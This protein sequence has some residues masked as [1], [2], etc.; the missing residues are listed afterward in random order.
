MLIRTHMEEL[1]EHTNNH[2]YERHRSNKLVSMGVNQDQSVFKEVKCVLQSGLCKTRLRA[3]L[4][5]GS[6]PHLAALQPRW[7]RNGPPTTP[8]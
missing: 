1:K 6:Y 4:T 5:N 3:S 7:P 2:L 8:S